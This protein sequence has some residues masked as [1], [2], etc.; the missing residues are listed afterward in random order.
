MIAFRRSSNLS[1]ISEFFLKNSSG[2]LYISIDGPSQDPLVKSQNLECRKIALSIQQEF[3]ERVKVHI[4]NENV[5]CSASVLTSCDWFFAQENYGL[6]LEDDCIPSIGFFEFAV[7][8]KSILEANS[9]IYLGCGT[10]FVP[11]GVTRGNPFL[12]SYA[13]I[14][15]WFTNSEKWNQIKRAIF[16]K[17]SKFNISR[18]YRPELAYWE[19]GRRR[20][21]EGFVDAWDT[22]LVAGLM[23]DKKKALLP[24]VNLVSNLGNDQAA[25]HNFADSLW[26]NLPVG[27]YRKDSPVLECPEGDSFLRTH[28]YKISFRHLLTTLI[29]QAIDNLFRS[30]G[31]KQLKLRVK[32]SH[33]NFK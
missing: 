22:A 20:A 21:L 23:R 3:P 8:A 19:A 5:G 31:Y 26:T 17:D 11:E 15:G 29:N 9:D 30:P 28:F 16:E 24:G 25:T 14:W 6:V 7:A 1:S 2:N 10:Q 4:R 12:S 33:I 27:E 18:F 32:N 13:L